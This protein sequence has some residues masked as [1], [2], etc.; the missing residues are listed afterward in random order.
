[1]WIAILKLVMF[2]VFEMRTV[3]MIYQARFSQELS[4]EGWLGLRRRLASL[5]LRFYMSLF[6]MIFLGF[7]FHSRP[8]ILIMIFYSFWWPQI[9]HNAFAGTRKPFHLTYLWG[10]AVL[11]LFMPLYFIGCPNNFLHI[12]L[13]D[14]PLF[15]ASFQSCLF[16]IFW[17][18]LQ[19][20]I[21]TAQD[22]YGSRFFVPNRFL[23]SKYDYFRYVRNGT[24]NDGGIDYDEE[25]GNLCECV[26]CYN[27]IQYTSGS[28]MITPCDHVFHKECLSRWL[29]VKLECPTCRGILPTYDED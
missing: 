17:V 7:I 8:K 3:V 4:S 25:N 15:E 14:Q 2:C 22:I 5:H 20:C 24:I 10:T 12:L 28:Y 6:V 13:L 18:I 29:D 27:G 23:P 16:L 11:R 19:A 9:Y 21:L 26:I 1:M